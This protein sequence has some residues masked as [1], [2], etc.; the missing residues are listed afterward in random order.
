[1][2]DW[3]VQLDD[4]D[5]LWFVHLITEAARSWAAESLGY[6]GGP[7]MIIHERDDVADLVDQMS[8]DGLMVAAPGEVEE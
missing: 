7:V 1:M 5:T 3:D 4:Q 6:S 8:A 2:P